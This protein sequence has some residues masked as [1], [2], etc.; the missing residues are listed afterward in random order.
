MRAS[1]AMLLLVCASFSCVLRTAR[2]EEPQ[3]PVQP[4]PETQELIEQW[5]A[6]ANKAEAADHYALL[7]RLQPIAQ[8]DY[9]RFARQIVYFVA[10]L[11][12][13]ERV[14]ATVV[15]RLFLFCMVPDGE[16][17]AALGPYLYS[18][19]TGARQVVWRLFPFSIGR[20]RRSDHP[21]F[22]HIRDYITGDFQKEETATPLK[23]AIFETAPN[24]AFLLFHSEAQPDELIS[25]RRKE[26][27]I[28]N[29]LYEKRQ[30]GG[31][32]GGMIE[33]ETVATIRELGKSKYWWARMFAAEIMVQNKEF[34]DAELLKNLAE[35]ENELVRQSVASIDNPDPLRHGKVDQ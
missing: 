20:S 3:F 23:R 2:S 6:T 15:C 27:V 10:H 16:V 29:A 4:H 5:L 25:F 1:S 17:A 35:D 9:G 26:R 12:G 22:S 19:H 31:L 33:E 28:D 24:A 18:N 14:R 32:P 13:E 8:K 34:R 21:D 11:Q 30:L 7:A